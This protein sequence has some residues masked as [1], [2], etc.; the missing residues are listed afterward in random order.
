M[1]R[2]LYLSGVTD[3]KFVFIQNDLTTVSVCSAGQ[4]TTRSILTKFVTNIP[5]KPQEIFWKKLSRFNQQT[6]KI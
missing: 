1:T 3:L 2:T 4:E 5:I 6:L